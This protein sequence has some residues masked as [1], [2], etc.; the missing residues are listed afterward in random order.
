MGWRCFI[1]EISTSTL[2]V[3]LKSV[4]STF[5][6]VAK[7]VLLKLNVLLY[8]ECRSYQLSFG[9]FVLCC[10]IALCCSVIASGMCSSQVCALK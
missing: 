5:A 9:H 2:F 8:Q 10:F 7:F 1:P 4:L 3:V 6:K